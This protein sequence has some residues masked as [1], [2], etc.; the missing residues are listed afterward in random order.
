VYGQRPLPYNGM[1]E[2]LMDQSNSN[3]TASQAI[4]VC[5]LGMHRS[6]TSVLSRLLNLLGV[7]LGK[8]L[9]A[10]KPDNPKGYWENQKLFDA[11]NELLEAIGSFYDD[12]RPLPDG[13]ED[14]PQ[15][16][17][18]RRRL[19]EIVNEEFAGHALWGFKDPRTSR[20]LPLW[21]G[22]L[23]TAGV[24]SRFILMARNPDEIARSLAAREGYSFNKSLLL[25]LIHWLEA[26]RNTRGK[27]R[28]VASYDQVMTD[29]PAAL[30]RLGTDL[31]IVWPTS[32]EMVAGAAAEFLD[33]NLRHHRSST[34]TSA[35]QAVSSG[36]DR[37]VARWAF[38]A[39]DL[40]LAGQT[41]PLDSAGFDRID[42]ELRQELPRLAGWAQTKSVE[43]QFN[44][45]ENWAAGLDWAVK[46]LTGQNNEL[47]LELD[48]WSP[49][50]VR[51]NQAGQIPEISDADSAIDIHANGQPPLNVCIVT[52]DIVGPVRNGG[53][54][55]SYQE[56]AMTLTEAG[57]HVTILYTL[58][59]HC[60]TGGLQHWTA[61]YLALGIDLVALPNSDEVLLQGSTWVRVSYQVWRWL[62][63][64]ESA[65]RK[66]D[67]IHF[68]DWRGH[69][70]YPTL[71]KRQGLG[72][73]KSI[74]CVG[75]H[76]P[77]L[78]QKYGMSEFVSD[79][80][81]LQTDFLE[82]S[83]VAL[84]DVLVS[85]S[86]YMLNWMVQQEWELPK[87]IEVRQNILA[88]K[89]DGPIDP[90]PRPVNQI[91]FFGRLETRKGIVLFCDA[92]DRLAGAETVQRQLQI[93][94][95]GKAS[96][97]NGQPAKEYLES[98]AAKW[99]FKWSVVNTLDSSDA[100]D[101]LRQPG[102]LA[103]IAS[104][105]DNSPNTV[106]ECLV[107]GIPFLCTNV[108]GNAELVAEADR[109]RV[110]FPPDG[111]LLAQK[112]QVACREGWAAAKV[113]VDPS[114]TKR[115][116][117]QWHRRIVREVAAPDA[118][119]GEKPLVSLC[120][121]HRNRPRLL[122][123]AI[124]SIRGLDY[125]NIEVILVDD[126]STEAEALTYLKELEGEFATRNWKLI[127]QENRY[128]GA[129]RNKAAAQA[130]GEYLLFMDDDN[131][132]KPHEV[133][134]F[135][136][137]ARYSR[138]D[139]LTCVKDVFVGD[140]PP[141]PNNGCVKHRWLPLGGAAGLSLFGN[142]I[143]DANAL[144]KRTVFQELGGFTED[145]GV[146][147]EDWEFFSRAVLRGYV[148]QV[149]PES[150]FWYRLAA[151]SMLRTT[152]NFANNMRSL[153]PYLSAAPRLRPALEYAKALYL[154]ISGV[155]DAANL[156]DQA[157]LEQ[158][159]ERTRAMAGFQRI[160][161]DYW[162]SYSWQLGLPLRNIILKVRGIRPGP[163]VVRSQ[164]ELDRFINDIRGSLTW[165][166]TGL[167]RL[168]GDKISRRRRG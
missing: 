79:L 21:H 66:F 64:S 1:A 149:V 67:V 72:L 156:Q 167:L 111:G 7:D 22:L 76:S 93:I 53:I 45:I 96:Q 145:F 155:A 51:R 50:Y 136:R 134:T 123:Q 16:E 29:W 153:R 25:A 88:A 3:P 20:L 138:A 23:E 46:N 82:R 73:G 33:P 90:A 163:P 101:Y 160:V 121:T 152:D 86:R 34:S 143:G 166:A 106:L 124:D 131:V 85:P 135:V 65:G 68:H 141:N 151:G 70:F 44:R 120:L 24:Q 31:Q 137:A 148:V 103:V 162:Y 19:L 95:L 158:S 142:F 11:H 43:H 147:H 132:A 37:D 75:T 127:R 112:L 26:E 94:F 38:E 71:A 157:A 6:G 97:V 58:G 74:L 116:W 30:T 89:S 117:Q 104:L 2:A 69:G 62:G 5:V 32:P 122:R 139:I 61:K 91:V 48:R 150:L 109:P 13:W 18:Y 39:Y 159:A 17:P 98:R 114:Q 154:Q 52:C 105:I 35:T 83:S 119:E 126:G 100:L 4:A 165:K 80:E 78:W 168:V 56:L 27:I 130:R 102:R 164:A 110:C 9:M 49:Q 118:P 40:L 92:V 42:A 115:Q 59:E 113:A 36:A 8:S 57:H 128:L 161:D 81:D 10:E 108:G 55:T 144:I 12:F 125:P 54:G 107:H 99:P 146:T 47:R 84:A 129:A 133:S 60:E 63:N 140:S 28:A 77:L 14:F 87:R 41:K 15:V